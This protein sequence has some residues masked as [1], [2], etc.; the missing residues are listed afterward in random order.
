MIEQLIR[1]LTVERVDDLPLLLAQRARM[2][3][4]ALL[5]THFPVHGPW[6]GA[7]TFGEVAVVWVA[8]RVSAGD[9]RLHHVETWASEHLQTRT[10][11]RG[12]RVRAVAF[13]EDR[14]GDLRE[15]LSDVKAWREF[16]VELHQALLRGYDV[17]AET[18][19]LEATTTKTYAGVEEDGRLQC[20]PSKDYRSDG[21][22]GK[23]HRATLD[24]LGLPLTT[25]VVSGNCADAPLYGPAIKAVQRP[26]GCGG[27]TSIGDCKMGA[28]ATRASVASR[29]E[30]GLCPL[31]GHQMPAAAVAPL[32]PPGTTG[33]HVL[34]P[35]TAPS[36]G[37]RKQAAQ[38]AEGYA[39]A[40]EVAAEGAGQRVAW[41]ERRRVVRSRVQAAQQSQS[42]ATR[43]RQAH[44]ELAQL[45]ERQP[46]KKRLSASARGAKADSIVAR[47]RVTDLSRLA[48]ATVQTQTPV[49]HTAAT[50]RRRSR[51]GGTLLWE[52]ETRHGAP[53]EGTIAG[54]F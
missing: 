4:A 3:V 30:Y 13:S 27:K 26:L 37:T 45:N 54:G 11:C 16:E 35:I 25:T 2:P 14:W 18:G 46:G 28:E 44:Y 38:V 19:R 36:G 22:Q 20:G 50:Q 23:G 42:L 6:A 41:R 10:A 7:L 43:L 48:V 1:L 52:P 24:P 17:P 51:V 53:D 32:I 29:Q 33:A 21:A 40:V 9:H 39:M 15:A 12:K 5:D 34:T 47:Q 31:A 49:R 8:A